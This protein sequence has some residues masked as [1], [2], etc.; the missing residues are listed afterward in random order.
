MFLCSV[1]SEFLVFGG[2]IQK[3]CE[4]W[5]I[6]SIVLVK[7]SEDEKVHFCWL[8]Q[9]CYLKWNYSESCILHVL[10]LFKP[11]Y[12]TLLKSNFEKNSQFEQ[13]FRFG[14]SSAS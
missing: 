1:G 9:P 3:V 12:Y 14:N 10:K 8:S 4:K 13:S 6:P 2:F 5:N 11:K 7:F